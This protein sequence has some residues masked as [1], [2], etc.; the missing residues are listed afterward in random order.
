VVPDYERQ[1]LCLASPTQSMDTGT[2]AKGQ[3]VR[4]G[5]PCSARWS[6]RSRRGPRRSLLSCLTVPPRRR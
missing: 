5:E 6:R 2:P 3:E 4:L 1:T